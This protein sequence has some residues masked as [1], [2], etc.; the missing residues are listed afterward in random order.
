MATLA[1]GFVSIAQ[2]QTTGTSPSTTAQIV[3]PDRR[4][5]TYVGPQP[6]SLGDPISYT[7][8]DGRGLRGE[9]QIDGTYMTVDRE[10]REN[11]DRDAIRP[12][13]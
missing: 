5:C 11:L 13:R 8:T 4:V 10:G 9:V 7:C 6:R 3:L 12:L 2:S 1:P